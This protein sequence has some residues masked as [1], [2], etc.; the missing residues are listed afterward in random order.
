MNYSAGLPSAESLG[1]GPLFDSLGVVCI[2]GAAIFV[3]V[4]LLYFLLRGR[5][6][7]S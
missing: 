3:I 4:I 5:R 1:F 6:D 7:Y 2:G